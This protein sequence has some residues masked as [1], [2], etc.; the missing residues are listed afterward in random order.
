MEFN[1]DRYVKTY[2]DRFIGLA[3]TNENE[4]FV[5][6]TSVN[7]VRTSSLSLTDSENSKCLYL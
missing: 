5:D 3:G 2:W 7:S 4:K 6:A 1:V